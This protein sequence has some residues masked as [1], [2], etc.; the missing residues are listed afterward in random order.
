M[1]NKVN[2]LNDPCSGNDP[3]IPSS[4]VF[5]NGDTG[6]DEPTR[7]RSVPGA[8]DLRALTSGIQMPEKSFVPKA[9]GTSA[10][11]SPK[12]GYITVMNGD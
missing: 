1:F 12:N 11:K 8:F 4:P 5:F 6:D 9:P 10:R 3:S 2:P 7:S